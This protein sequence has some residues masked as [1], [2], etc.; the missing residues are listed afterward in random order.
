MFKKLLSVCLALIMVLGTSFSAFAATTNSNNRV[1][2]NS[3]VI[4]NED[5]VYVDDGEGNIVP[6]TITENIYVSNNN[7]IMPRSFS[8]TAKVG[9]KRSYTVKISN[10]AM[11][12]PSLAAGALSFTAKKNAAQIAA[13]AIA[14]KLGANFI[15]GLNVASWILSA[16]AMANAISGK[17]GIQL[18]VGLKYTETY[19]HK[20]GYSVYGWST[21]SL[22]VSRY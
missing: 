1:I 5:V 17:A 21:T 12:M 13:K 22:S 9:E 6:V 14:A 18:T 2:A 11:G 15:P 19:L 10:E 20:E 4:T 7:G 8:P 3:R 16:A